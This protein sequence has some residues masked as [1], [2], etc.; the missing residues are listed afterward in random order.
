MPDVNHAGRGIAILVVCAHVWSAGVDAEQP[1]NCCCEMRIVRI[2]VVVV[3][4]RQQRVDEFVVMRHLDRDVPVLDGLTF[5][6]HDRLECCRQTRD[7]TP[8]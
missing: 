8:I 1:R 5:A 7:Q 3:N 2:E 6:L 4:Y